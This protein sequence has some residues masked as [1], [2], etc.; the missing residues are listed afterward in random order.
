MTGASPAPTGVNAATD[1]VATGSAHSVET[2]PD[3]SEL[4][5]AYTAGPVTDEAS[6]RTGGIGNCTTDP[7]ETANGNPATRDLP[8]GTTV[9]YFGDYEIQQELGRGGMGVVYKARQVSLNRPVALKTIRAGVLADDAEMRRF[10]NEAE[11][12]AL[13]DHS[14]IVPVYEVGEHDGQKY[15]S[16]KLVE[17]GNLAEQL[18][19]LRADHRAAATLLAQTAEAV[20]HAHMRGILHRDLKPANILIDAQGHPHITDFGLAKRVEGDVEL[21]VSGAIMGTPA[22]MSPEQAAGRRRA[23]TT[24]TDV[25][26]LGAILYALLTGKAPFGGDSLIDTLEKVRTKPPEPPTNLN[27]KTPR[28]LETIC[29]KCLE[30]EPRRRYSSAHEVAVDLD[31]WLQSRPITARRVGPV[32]RAWLWCK[33]KPIV[34]ASAVS[35]VLA[36]V[37]GTAA[38]IAVQTRANRLLAKKNI[39]LNQANEQVVR[40]NA[41]LKSSNILL[42]QQRVLAMDRETQAIDAV[43]K[44]RDAVANEPELKNNPA[45]EFLRKRLLK[46][47]LTFFNALRDRLQADHDT[48][49]EAL[50]RLST[51]GHDLGVL[52]SEIGNKQDALI[53]F[54][55]SL[56]IRQKLADANPANTDYQLDTAQS[57]EHIAGLQSA[58]GKTVQAI[59]ASRSSLLIRGKLAA[60]HPDVAEFQAKLARSHNNMGAVLREGGKS[61]DAISWLKSALALQQ[62]LVET[63]PEVTAFQYELAR[64]NHNIGSL[65][66]DTGKPAEALLYCQRALAIQQKLVDT[67]SGATTFQNDL[68]GSYQN[69]GTILTALGKPSEALAAY[70]SALLIQQKLS[71]K[72]PTVTEFQNAMAITYNNMGVLLMGARKPAAAIAAYERAL[73]VRRKL[74]DANPTVTAFQSTLATAYSNI[75]MVQS[76]A[77]KPAEALAAFNSALSIRQMLADASPNV[78]ALQSELAAIHNTIGRMLRANGKPGE[79]ILAYERA[80]AIQRKLAQDHPDSPD[81]ASSLGATLN[82]IAVIDLYAKRFA[83]ARPRLQEAVEWQGKA[84]ATKP[85][86]RVYRQFLE[87]HLVNLIEATRRLGDSGGQSAAEHELAKLRNSDPAMASLDARL[88]G[89][90]KRNQQPRSQAD[91]LQLAQRAYTKG[92]HVTAARL[93]SEALEAEPKLGDDRQAQ[94]RYNAACAAALAASGAEKSD[95]AP[96]AAD[97][98]KLRQQALEWLKSELA[99]WAKLVESGQPEAKASIA[100]TLK[101]WHEDS[102]LAGIRD[103]KALDELPEA[104]HAGWRTLW[105]DIAAVLE[106]ARA[107]AVPSK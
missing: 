35:V 60:M 2:T 61:V 100:Q 80:L 39:D 10:Q 30:K 99:I 106:K 26:G 43:K 37:I 57:Y 90:I 105:A 89:Y 93:W 49:P 65:L 48:R 77:G 69:S 12:V 14:G 22:Y 21:T 28:D 96:D 11:A 36:V 94:I 91:R 33:R 75:G 54:Q 41:E 85:E 6:P 23:I 83:D 7:I 4:T 81:Y 29:L 64:S 1:P 40:V 107:A 79:A 58:S 86:G 59:E 98:V 24:A 73:A 71:A 62:K 20:H 88:A 5:G 74:A 50:A 18:D 63:N 51:V 53:A 52:T 97:K 45:L 84:L 70:E 92:F 15:F 27:A 31:N 44:F 47:P 82:N 101:H 38:V 72:N 8:R 19:S 102:D 34:A 56:A 87:N 17:G 103:A 25:Y 68:A 76:G 16:M 46:E 32:E 78:T 67:H 9:R 104:E 55:E 66:N 13:L 3:N 42:D 95:Q